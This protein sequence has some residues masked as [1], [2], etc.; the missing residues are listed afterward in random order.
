MEARDA[1]NSDLMN[2]LRVLEGTMRAAPYSKQY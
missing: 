1:I 2:M